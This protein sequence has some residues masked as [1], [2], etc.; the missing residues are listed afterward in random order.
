MSDGRKG[1]TLH[2]RGAFEQYHGQVEGE[3]AEEAAEAAAASRRAVERE[4]ENRRVGL[5]AR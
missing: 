1:A 2:L 5:P 3:E 4:A